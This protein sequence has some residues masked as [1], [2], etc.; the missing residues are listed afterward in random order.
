MGPFVRVCVLVLPDLILFRR[1]AQHKAITIGLGGLYPAPEVVRAILAPQE[2]II[3]RIVDL[4][5]YIY[6]PSM[7]IFR[8]LVGCG[9][10]VWA[11]E[12]AREF[13]HCQVL[14]VDLAPVPTPKGG[15]PSNCQFEVADITLGLSHLHGQ[16]DIVFARAIGLGLKDVPKTLDIME[17][18]TKP[19]G[20]LIWLDAD[21]DFLSG[22]PP[23][24]RP[25]WSNLNPSGSYMQRAN[26]GWL[27]HGIA[28]NCLLVFNRDSKVRFSGRQ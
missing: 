27:G 3:K 5:R 17:A 13:P 25:F 9:T 6:I 12:M 8:T 10:G 23:V 14:G 21:F 2:G 4:G 16:C 28:L 15:I 18:C 7:S 1:N 20:A 24:Y 19:G 26:Y 11:C 22:W